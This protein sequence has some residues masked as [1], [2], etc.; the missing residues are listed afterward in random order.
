MQD[1]LIEALRGDGRRQAA[2]RMLRQV[3]QG[4]GGL[5]LGATFLG[6]RRKTRQ[7]CCVLIIYYTGQERGVLRYNYSFMG[8]MSHDPSG[9]EDA[10]L[11]ALVCVAFPLPAF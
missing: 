5:S 3:G 2:H 6:D 10:A 9:S 4:W 8:H 11:F 1:E 7:E